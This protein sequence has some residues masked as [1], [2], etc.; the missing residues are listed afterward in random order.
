MNYPLAELIDRYSILLLKK[1]RLPED[2]SLGLQ[3]SQF[4]SAI[5]AYNYPWSFIF[6]DKLL[7]VNGK[8]W[9]LESDI[10]KG[11]EELLGLTEVGK[12]ALAIRDLNKERISIKNDVAKKVGDFLDIK[13][14]H[15]SQD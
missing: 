7:K 14:D 6:A 1:E 15:A 3:L 8:I 2:K 5:R 9:D 10:R 12:R 11:R 13:I 4:K